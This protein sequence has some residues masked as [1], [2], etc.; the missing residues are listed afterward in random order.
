ME[1][2][3]CH[4]TIDDYLKRYNNA[5]INLSQSGPD[6]TFEDVLAYVTKHNL[7]QDAM[8][9]Y[10]DQREKYDVINS[11]NKLTLGYSWYLC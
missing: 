9:I 3:L 8:R 7:H 5:L 1:T 6:K 10:K 4:F 11:P 2:K